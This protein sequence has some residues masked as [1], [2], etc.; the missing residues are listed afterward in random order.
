MELLE[1][2]MMFFPVILMILLLLVTSYFKFREIW[3]E[4]K[5]NKVPK[6]NNG[7]C[8]DQSLL[9]WIN[10]EADKLAERRDLAV[11]RD[12]IEP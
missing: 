8:K 1:L 12:A 7:P 10:Y 6:S 9:D 5:R 3:V 11:L 2:I 4:Y